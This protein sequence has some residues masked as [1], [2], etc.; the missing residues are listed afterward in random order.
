[1]R[2]GRVAAALALIIVSIAMAGSDCSTT[3]GECPG[4]RTSDGDCCTTGCACGAACIDC[5]DTCRSAQ[6]LAGDGAP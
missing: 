2:G 4:G 1:M 6:P 5:D 3:D